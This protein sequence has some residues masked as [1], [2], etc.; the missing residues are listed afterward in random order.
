MLY[1]AIDQHAK[2][3][4]V[5]VRN[6]DGDT[7]LRRQVST[8]TEKIEAFFR[9]LT[10]M[11][12]QFMAILEVC[13]SNDWLI[14]RLRKWN[15]REIVLIHPENPSRKKTDRRDAHKLADLLWLNSERLAVVKPFMACDGFTS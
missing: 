15:C 5:C 7:V 13:G 10:E 4:T 8:R 14:E 1:L 2:Q 12:T 11:D 6:Q 9:H 3:I